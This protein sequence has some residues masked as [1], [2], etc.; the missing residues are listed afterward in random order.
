MEYVDGI[1]L[2]EGIRRCPKIYPR[3]AVALLAELCRAFIGLHELGVAHR[4]VKPANILLDRHGGIKL[5]D[6]GLI[7]DAQGILRLLEDE[8]GASI[9]RRVFDE[10]IDFGTLAGTIEY[11]SPE[12]LLD[13][14]VADMSEAW[15]GT[16]SD[17]YSLGVILLEV[18]AGRRPFG[19]SPIKEIRTT[20]QIEDYVR[21][22]I[23][24]TGVELGAL[25]GVDPA[26]LSILNKA[27]CNDPRTR[28]PDC[29]VMMEELRTYL[30]TGAGVRI[31]A[32]KTLQIPLDA[33]IASVPTRIL[34]AEAGGVGRAGGAA[35]AEAVFPESWGIET[36][37]E[38]AMPRP[39]RGPEA[40]T[41][42]GKKF[43]ESIEDDETTKWSPPTKKRR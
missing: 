26:L 20:R 38:S 3:Q 17:V 29:R 31:D 40:R 22:R 42:R 34:R 36:I 35:H 23:E 13:S 33:F 11:M 18:L 41:Q 27:L 21:W 12:Q 25:E 37:D 30:A 2:Q 8:Q 39:G 4:D 24:R 5:I 28:Q 14:M 43:A 7:R 6:F 1:T 19:N 16:A 32:S 15:T 10:E 9:D